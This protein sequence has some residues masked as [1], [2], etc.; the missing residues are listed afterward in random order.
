M[1]VLAFIILLAQAP[2]PPQKPAPQQPMPSYQQFLP[3]FAENRRQLMARITKALTPQQHGA[4][5]IDLGANAVADEPNVTKLTS[6]IDSVL[7]PPARTA[8]AAAFERYVIAQQGLGKQ[9]QAIMR[10]Q[11]SGNVQAWLIGP[12]PR[13]VAF[14]PADAARLLASL[15]VDMGRPLARATIVSIGS[16]AVGVAR[17]RAQM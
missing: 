13:P 16:T 3:E 9:I 2:A 12:T 6:E 10:Q 14:V 11:Q 7:T 8:I 4:I 15:P 1:I 17:L 5:A